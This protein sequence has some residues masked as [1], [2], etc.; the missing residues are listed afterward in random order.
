MAT[1]LYNG[2]RVDIAMLEAQMLSV[3]YGYTV[4]PEPGTFALTMILGMGLLARRAGRAA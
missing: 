3:A 1:N 2:I 4:V